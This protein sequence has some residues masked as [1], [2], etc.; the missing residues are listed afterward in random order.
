MC[1][2]LDT[3]ILGEAIGK[4]PKA[5]GR[6]FVKWLMRN[7]NPL[8]YG[9]SK[10]IKELQKHGAFLELAEELDRS[11]NLRRLDDA[12]V[13][14]RALRFSSSDLVVS[15]DPHILA[16]AELGDARLL[17]SNDKELH[18]DFKNPQLL[19]GTRSV[20]STNRSSTFSKSKRDLLEKSSCK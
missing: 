16:V 12:S 4:N 20:Y 18:Q 1:V 6:G 5:A 7:S 3:N 11:G 9:G 13:D 10:M 15:D 8:V 19:K 17:Y 2:I 14:I